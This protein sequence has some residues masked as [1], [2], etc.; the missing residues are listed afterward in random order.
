MDQY[1]EHPQS[2]INCQHLVGLLLHL[3][4][5]HTLLGYWNI[6]KQ[7]LDTSLHPQILQCVFFFPPLPFI[8][9]PNKTD[10]SYSPIIYLER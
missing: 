6:L 10:I 3:P 7:I 9:T 1:N 2:F 8:I 4:I 5:I